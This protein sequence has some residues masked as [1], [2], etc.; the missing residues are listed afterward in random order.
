MYNDRIGDLYFIED[1]ENYF[2]DNKVDKDKL[3]TG[4]GD[5][6]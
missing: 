4:I 6:I 3:V 1:G 2:K 5:F